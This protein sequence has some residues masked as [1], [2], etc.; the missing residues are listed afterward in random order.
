V[1]PNDLQNRFVFH[2]PTT[3]DKVSA[4]EAI[5]ANCLKFASDLNQKLPEGREKSLA[6]TH[7]EEVM[8]WANAAIARS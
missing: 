3:G 1:D 7:L 2:A 8:F 5:R 4:H 6:I